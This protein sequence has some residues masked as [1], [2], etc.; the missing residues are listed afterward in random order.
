MA[1]EPIEADKLLAGHWWRIGG[2]ACAE[3]YPDHVLFRTTGL[4]EA[5]RAA[6]KGKIWHTGDYEVTDSRTV[7]IQ[8][9][10]NVSLR[11]TIK[12]LSEVRLTL[13]DERGCVFSF[14]RA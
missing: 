2:P 11:Y 10:E 8:A 5:P 14:K 9:A 13:E 1:G 6:E 7:V 4:Y 3:I 12:E